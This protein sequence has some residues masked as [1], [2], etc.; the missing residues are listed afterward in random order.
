MSRSRI[1]LTI[2]AM[3]QVKAVEIS[4]DLEFHCATQAR[5][6]MLSHRILFYGLQVTHIMPARSGATEWK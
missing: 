6:N 1:F 3:T 2:P 5:T 4:L